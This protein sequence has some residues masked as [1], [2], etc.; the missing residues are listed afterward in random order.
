ML[1]GVVARRVDGVRHVYGGAIFIFKAGAHDVAAAIFIGGDRD[2]VL[3]RVEP[4]RNLEGE[5]VVRGAA[6]E[7]AGGTAIDLDRDGIIRADSQ[8]DTAAD[9]GVIDDIGIGHAHAQLDVRL[10]D[11]SALQVIDAVGRGGGRQDRLG[12][13]GV[14]ACPEPLHRRRSAEVG[15]PADF[16]GEATIIRRKDQPI[17][18]DDGLVGDL[19]IDVADPFRGHNI[20]GYVAAI[21]GGQRVGRGHEDLSYKRAV[22]NFKLAVAAALGL[23]LGVSVRARLVAG[24][25]DRGRDRQGLEVLIFEADAHIVAAAVFEGIDRDEVLAGIKLRGALVGEAGVSRATRGGDHRP[26]VD[27]HRAGIV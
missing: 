4:D 3:A 15:E 24:G 23:R 16:R 8:L 26:A 21:P 18:G 22:D 9:I 2:E 19:S 17:F 7:G 20:Y 1:P 11:V 10:E 12:G 6:L 25:V 14:G 27:A 13:K 5:R